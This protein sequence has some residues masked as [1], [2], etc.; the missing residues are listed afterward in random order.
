MYAR[1]SILG[2][3]DLVQLDDLGH[4]ALLSGLTDLT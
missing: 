3:A 1:K 4:V 2:L